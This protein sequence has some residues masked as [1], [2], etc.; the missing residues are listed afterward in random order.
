MKK[1]KSK[2]EMYLVGYQTNPQGK[3]IPI[4]STQKPEEE[5]EPIKPPSLPGAR[6]KKIIHGFD[7]TQ[8]EEE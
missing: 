3:K 8:E 7:P 1:A 6:R 5:V 4:Y 2:R